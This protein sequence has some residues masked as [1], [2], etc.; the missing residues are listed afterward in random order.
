MHF[1]PGK[2]YIE[3]LSTGKK[4]KIEEKQGTFEVGVWVPQSRVNT[5]VNNDMSRKIQPVVCAANETQGFQRQDER[6]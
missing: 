6:F 4:T 1:E 2:C 3:H 5:V